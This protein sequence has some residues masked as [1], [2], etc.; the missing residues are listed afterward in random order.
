MAKITTA[1]LCLDGLRL[2][3]RF[4]R[5]AVGR[6]GAHRRRA[7][8]LADW[9]S[10]VSHWLA[11]D[12]TPVSDEIPPEEALPEEEPERGDIREDITKQLALLFPH[13]RLERI[14]ERLR[15][16]DE[17]D[18]QFVID[19]ISATFTRGIEFGAVE[20]T[21]QQ[22]EL[23]QQTAPATIEIVHVELP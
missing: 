10:D 16:Q 17:D 23:G 11:W 2:R 22:I 4:D 12:A 20:V 3:R 7:F 8:G 18:L 5:V 14:A 9:L 19:L 15:L 6:D 21:A 13:D 1:S